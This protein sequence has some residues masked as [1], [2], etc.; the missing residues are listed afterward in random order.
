MFEFSGVALRVSNR[1]KAVASLI[2]AAS[3]AVVGLMSAAIARDD[4]GI[5]QFFAAQAQVEASGVPRHRTGRGVGFAQDAYHCGSRPV[6]RKPRR[7]P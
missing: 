5:H 6:P 3:A 7:Q 4:A 2:V 1:P